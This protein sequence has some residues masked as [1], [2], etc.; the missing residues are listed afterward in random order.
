[1][2][3]NILNDFEYIGHGTSA[4]VEEAYVT[5]MF[6]GEEIVFDISHSAMNSGSHQSFFRVYVDDENHIKLLKEAGVEF[7]IDDY[8]DGLEVLAEGDLLKDITYIYGT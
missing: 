3:Y 2:S 4:I 7:K 5:L 6:E 1:M 8:F